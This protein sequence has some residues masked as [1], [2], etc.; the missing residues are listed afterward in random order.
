MNAQRLAQLLT[1]DFIPDTEKINNLENSR[2]P[3][4]GDGMMTVVSLA[5][6][7]LHGMGGVHKQGFLGL[8]RAGGGRSRGPTC[9][10]RWRWP[11]RTR[12][13]RP[14]LPPSQR[15]GAAAHA[16]QTCNRLGEKE[17][18]EASCMPFA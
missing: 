2:L 6:S 16:A 15:S 4:D 10:R 5:L 7:S 12:R 8:R 1:E 9:C 3:V 14:R 11:P 17:A 13:T 18:L